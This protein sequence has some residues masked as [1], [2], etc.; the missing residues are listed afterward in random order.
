M[1]DC[2]GRDAEKF[3]DMGN[4]VLIPYIYYILSQTNL[5]QCYIPFK[6]LVNCSNWFRDQNLQ[7]KSSAYPLPSV[8]DQF[9]V[10]IT[11][12]STSNSNILHN[13]EIARVERKFITKGLSPNDRTLVICERQTDIGESTT[14]NLSRL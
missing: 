4:K 8:N 1:G 5:K 11:I 12:F 9:K 13:K 3:K 6:F 7:I 14:M 10:F 2:C